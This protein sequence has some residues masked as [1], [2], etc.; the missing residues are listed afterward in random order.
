MSDEGFE[1]FVLLPLDV[2]KDILELSNVYTITNEYYKFME[3]YRLKKCMIIDNNE[4]IEAIRKD[5]ISIV[6]ITDN[7]V[8]LQNKVKLISQF[9]IYDTIEENKDIKRIAT[10]RIIEVD[11]NKI[12]LLYKRKCGMGYTTQKISIDYE[13]ML[14]IPSSIDTTLNNRDST[15]CNNHKREIKL[16]YIKDTYDNLTNLS[17][18]T[19]DERNS[20]K[21]KLISWIIFCLI[22]REINY[23]NILGYRLTSEEI[24]YDLDLL[25]NT[26]ITNI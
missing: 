17:N 14:L 16:N 23:K 4:I 22:D 18:N 3:D 15:L 10:M 11:S 5:N 7:H 12:T 26:L 2:Q 19:T 9:V 21:M 20:I 8:T 25:Y 1:Q 6:L 13:F 24:N